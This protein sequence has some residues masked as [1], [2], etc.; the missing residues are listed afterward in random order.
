MRSCD[1]VKGPV[2][3]GCKVVTAGCAVL[4]GRLEA[5]PQQEGLALL[6]QHYILCHC[7]SNLQCQ[8]TSWHQ[9]LVPHE[10]PTGSQ[11]RWPH[12][13]HLSKGK[14]APSLLG[15]CHYSQLTVPC[16][17]PNSS[18]DHRG[19]TPPPAAEAADTLSCMAQ[20]PHPEEA[21]RDRRTQAAELGGHPNMTLAPPTSVSHRQDGH[22]GPGDF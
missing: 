19:F 1:K 21:D 11:V 10:P 4:R 15:S 13:T 14:E 2:L 16:H 18:P 3:T 20:C 17:H 6:T 5:R 9:G 12:C 8:L 22:L 7:L